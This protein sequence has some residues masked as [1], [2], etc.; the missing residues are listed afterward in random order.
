MLI[1]ILIDDINKQLLINK[2]K[3]EEEYEEEIRS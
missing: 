3:G 2:S 1:I